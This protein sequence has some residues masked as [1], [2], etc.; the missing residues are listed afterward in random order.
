MSLADYQA[1]ARFLAR[2]DIALRSFILVKPP[3]ITTEE[4]ALAWAARSLD[5]AFECGAT[6][7]TLIPTRAGNGALEA[8][9]AAGQFSPP[10]L[11]TVEAAATYG[12]GRTSTRVFADLW[13]IEK[14]MHC[15]HCAKARIA[16]LR[17]MNLTQI[18][19]AIAPCPSC[20]SVA[21]V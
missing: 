6:V 5:Y 10:A 11:A 19:P 21:D 20:E 4:E 18:V 8:L 17:T 3:F 16:R 9:Q 12:I 13:D 14:L 2:H 1:A 15:P 7:A